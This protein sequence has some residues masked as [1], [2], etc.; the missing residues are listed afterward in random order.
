MNIR[1]PK[2]SIAISLFLLGTVAAYRI[3]MQ[4]T[5]VG[6]EAYHRRAYE[7]SLD[8]PL[9]IGDWEG[10]DE[11]V[12][13]GA[14][15][16]LHPNVLICRRFANAK[17]GMSVNL[18]IVQCPDARDILGHYPPVCYPAHGW[19]KGREDVPND[20]NVGARTY[21]GMEYEFSRMIRDHGT[22]SDHVLRTRVCDFMLLP[23]GESSPDMNFVTARAQGYRERFFGAAQVQVQFDADVPESLRDEVFDTLVGAH[24]ALLDHIG[25]GGK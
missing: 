17:T 24:Q 14:V 20:W 15:E 23:D 10:K 8:C 3:E 5:P 2:S 25:S 6:A 18:L 13:Q 11:K 16:L 7:I 21:H 4:K 12:M 22:G 1:S 9:K 19:L